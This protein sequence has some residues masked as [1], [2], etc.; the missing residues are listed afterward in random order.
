[1]AVARFGGW[2]AQA[3]FGVAVGGVGGAAGARF[4]VAVWVADF[5]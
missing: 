2:V 3:R 5:V 1:M 4:G